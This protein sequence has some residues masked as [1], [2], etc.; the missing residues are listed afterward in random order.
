V[1]R[2]LTD[3]CLVIWFTGDAAESTLTAAERTS[4]ESYL[5]GGGLLFLS[6]QNIGQDIGATT[7]YSD[8]LHAA[9]VQPTTNVHTLAGV[10]GDEIGDGLSILTAGSPGAGNQTS[11]DIIAPAAGADSIVMYLPGDCAGIK[12]DSGTYRVVYLGFGFEG[13]ASRPD[14]G[15][16]N[17]WYVLRRVIKWLGCP[18]V[19]IEEEEG[20]QSIGLEKRF[21]KIHPSPLG[22]H[23]EISFALTEAES[24]GRVR[25]AV[26]DTAGRLVVKLLD[27]PTEPRVKVQF[28]AGALPSGVYFCHLE[29]GSLS[30]S[31]QM[32][33]VK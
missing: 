10:S 8:Y 14:I 32:V 4:L 33:V 7:F 19:G 21:L 28:D 3:Y 20:R 11:Q 16:D 27:G 18:T 6:G 29:V 26:Y 23:T 9:F 1:A 5:D 22:T 2:V 15:Y 13:I 25:L 31:K 30:I 17:N 24:R 12:Y